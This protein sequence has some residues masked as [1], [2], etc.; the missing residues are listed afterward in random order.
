MAQVKLTR[1]QALVGLGVGT[2]QYPS[3]LYS[4]AADKQEGIICD[5][6]CKNQPSS[7]IKFA[8]FFHVCLFI[9][10]DLFKI[11]TQIFYTY[12]I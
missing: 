12:G 3:Q 10:Y 8:L 5:R 7:R 1:T 2:S 6:A 4:L 9:T 11:A